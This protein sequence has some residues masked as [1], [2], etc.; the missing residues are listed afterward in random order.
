MKYQLENERSTNPLGLNTN[1]RV[2]LI[3]NCDDCHTTTFEGEQHQL[4][5][6]ELLIQRN[7][8]TNPRNL[9]ITSGDNKCLSHRTA[10]LHPRDTDLQVQQR[11]T[12]HTTSRTHLWCV[13]MDILRRV[14]VYKCV[15]SHFDCGHLQDIPKEFVST[16]AIVKFPCRSLKHMNS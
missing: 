1:S 10:A 7:P 11:R 4:G 15:F 9:A 3:L 12:F 8:T 2:S 6:T 16:S 5:R 14:Y 13:R